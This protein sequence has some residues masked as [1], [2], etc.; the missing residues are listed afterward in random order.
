MAGCVRVAGQI[1]YRPGH[2]VDNAAIIEVIPAEG[3][4]SRGGEKLEGALT[5]FHIDPTGY[6]CLDIGSATGGFTDCLLQ[7]GAAHVHSVDVGK[8]QLDWRLRNDKRVVLHE[9]INARYL[10]FEDI[11]ETVELATVDVSF[12]SL[13]LILPPLIPIVRERGELVALVKPQFEAGKEKVGKGGVVRDPNTHVE[14]LESLRGFVERETP[15]MVAGA[16]YSPLTGPA[17]NIEFFL[18][19]RY[20]VGPSQSEPKIN[21]AT[22]VDRAHTHMSAGC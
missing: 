5:D 2:M 21:L 17:G 15:W 4:V 16:T 13:R 1:V 3:Y 19:L 12:I 10:T 18:H 6:T 7:H 9:G 20:K 8:G 22:M 11:G 14:I